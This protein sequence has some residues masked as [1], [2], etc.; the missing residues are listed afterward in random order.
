MYSATFIFKKKQFDDAFHRLDQTIT[1]FAK[2]TTDYIGEES[3]ENTETGCISNV[4]YWKSMNG[5]Q[6]LMK[7]PKHLEAKANHANWLDGYQVV[8]SQVLR[9]YGDGTIAHPAANLVYVK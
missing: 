3:W 7:H 4:Y 8:I 6:E 9:S 1:E 5:L 2:H